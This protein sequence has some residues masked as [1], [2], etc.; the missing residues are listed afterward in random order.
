MVYGDLIRVVVVGAK[1]LLGI[2]LNLVSASVEETGLGL[3]H[4]LLL[5]EHCGLSIQIA[6]TSFIECRDVDLNMEKSGLKSRKAIRLVTALLTCV[7]LR[8]FGGFG[9]LAATEVFFDSAALTL[10][11]DCSA[12]SSAS[13]ESSS[14]NP[15]ATS[16]PTMSNTISSS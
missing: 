15:S 6:N 11:I 16:F 2:G 3:K 14:G 7:T 10:G 5:F 1:G 13:I 9:V 12:R 8:R 4:V